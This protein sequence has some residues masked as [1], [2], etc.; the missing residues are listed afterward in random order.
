[1]TVVN[2][3]CYNRKAMI[4]QS[5]LK[6]A[7]IIQSW[8]R[9]IGFEVCGDGTLVLRIPYGLSRR[10]LEQ[11]V[12]KKNHGSSGPRK[13]SAGNSR[14]TGLWNW[15]RGRLSCCSDRI[16]PCIGSREKDSGSSQGT[17][18]WAW[19]KPGRVWSAS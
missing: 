2:V 10:Q 7:R 1:M 8:R 13:R 16:A 19:K 17:F 5:L 3:L 11:V 9:S 6:N 4:D 15:R 12:A 18:L 14:N